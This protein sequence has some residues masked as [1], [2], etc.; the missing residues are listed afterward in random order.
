[1]IIVT[2]SG[3]LIGSEAVAMFSELG[4]QVHGV[5]NNLRRYFFG[6]NASTQWRV[7]ELENRFPNY[8][9]H[10][11]DLRNF[12]AVEALVK[13]MAPELKYIIHAAAQPSHDWAAKE[14]LTDFSV[15][16][17]A[18]HYLLEA[19]RKHAPNAAFCLSFHQQ[20]L[21]RHAEFFALD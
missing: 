8:T 7:Q 12:E 3:G 21:W 1:M 4:M 13:S 18:T 20:G 5:D 16:A 9:H 17:V 19:V 2:G 10:N 15:N 11:I 14:P 6:E